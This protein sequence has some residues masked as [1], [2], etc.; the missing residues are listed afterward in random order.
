MA[1]KRAEENFDFKF[2]NNVFLFG[3][4]PQDMNAGREAG[5][6]TVGVTTG[7]YSQEDLEN[8]DAS[9]VVDNLQDTQKILDIV[10]KKCG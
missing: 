1:I 6:I 7:I 10:L 9:Y 5:V 2:D 3:D 4:A 8:A